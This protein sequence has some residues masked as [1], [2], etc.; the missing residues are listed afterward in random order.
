MQSCVSTEYH[1]SSLLTSFI[2]ANIVTLP[3][4]SS[5]VTVE[6]R[7]VSAG[8]LVRNRTHQQEAQLP[9]RNS[10]SVVHVYIGW[11]TDCAMQRTP[12]NRRGYTISDIQ[13]L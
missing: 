2:R 9:Q 7:N 5:D 10:A 13:T 1:N 11:L 8:S 12:Q 3:T 4:K 6:G